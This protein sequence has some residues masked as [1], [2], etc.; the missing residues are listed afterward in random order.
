[1]VF[2]N[3]N[4]SEIFVKDEISVFFIFGVIYEVNDQSKECRELDQKLILM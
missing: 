4:N 1:M 3:K 2:N